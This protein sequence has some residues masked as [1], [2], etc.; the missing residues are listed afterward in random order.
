MAASLLPVSL[1]FVYV[2]ALILCS[3]NSEIIDMYNYSQFC[4]VKL[5]FEVAAL[6][7]V[8]EYVGVSFGL[9]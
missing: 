6:H 8:K 5:H 9:A 3:Q 4:V 2:Y 7:G 1:I